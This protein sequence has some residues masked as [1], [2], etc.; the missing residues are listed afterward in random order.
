MSEGLWVGTGLARLHPLKRS[1]IMKPKTGCI[2]TLP[3]IRS[4]ICVYVSCQ[5]NLSPRAEEKGTLPV[6]FRASREAGGW[7]C[8][9]TGATLGV[10]HR[11]H[12]LF[13]PA[14]QRLGMKE[15]SATFMT[16]CTQPGTSVSRTDDS[17]TWV[18][19]KGCS[20][21]AEHVLC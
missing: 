4:L 19:R 18:W 10:P 20:S 7:T 11:C 6:F 15:E 1:L 17:N 8:V 9:G 5:L 14:V 13:F 12:A 3:G 2:Y 21:D 16:L